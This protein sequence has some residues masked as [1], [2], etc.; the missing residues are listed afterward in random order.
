MTDDRRA[1]GL[2]WP[3]KQS[4]LRYIAGMPDGRAILA[5]GA[6]VSERD[7]V[8]FAAGDRPDYS[9]ATGEGTVRFVGEVVFHGHFGMMRIR[10]AD[11]WLRI[12]GGRGTLLID[13][14]ADRRL[15]LVEAAIDFAV[16]CGHRPVWHAR[17][18]RLTGDGSDLFGGVYGAGEPFDRFVAVVAGPGVQRP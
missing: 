16:D 18:V 1:T 10:I 3:I 14:G 5:G 11:P 2:M 7:G 4:F 8:I 13:G 6:R 17:D 9:A 15:A 12:A